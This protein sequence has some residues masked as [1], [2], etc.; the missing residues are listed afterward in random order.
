[1]PLMFKQPVVARAQGLHHGE[2]RCPVRKGR[3]F[4][5]LIDDAKPLR[6]RV[7]ARALQQDSD[8]L[9]D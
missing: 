6:V 5:N 2:L 9:I 8:L 1:M 7:S 3:Q 4:P